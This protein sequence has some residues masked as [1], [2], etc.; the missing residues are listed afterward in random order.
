MNGLLQHLGLTLGDALL[1]GVIVGQL[2][3]G[4]SLRRH[5]ERI[6]KTAAK[7]AR[8]AEKVGLKEGGDVGE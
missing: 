6:G 2:L 1:L 7:V 4:R 5:G 8:L 3:N